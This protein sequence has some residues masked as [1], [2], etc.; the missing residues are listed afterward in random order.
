MLFHLINNQS[1]LSFYYQ[2]NFFKLDFLYSL[3]FIMSD[4]NT[5]CCIYAIL[6]G[7]FGFMAYQPL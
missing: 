3:D 5:A 7:L 2:L 6:V 1:K 4:T